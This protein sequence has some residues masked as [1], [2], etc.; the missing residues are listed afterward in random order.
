LSA[1][2]V[3]M[4]QPTCIS[5]SDFTQH[6]REYSKAVPSQIILISGKRLVDFGAFNLWQNRKGKQD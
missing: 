2:V 5:T 3:L 6:A 1:T 4:P